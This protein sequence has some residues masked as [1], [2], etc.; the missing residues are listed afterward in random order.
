MRRL[1]TPK[2]V[3]QAV[4]FLCSNASSYITGTTI[5]VNGGGYV[6]A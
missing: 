6:G 1:G 2:D 5:H 4:A 3:A